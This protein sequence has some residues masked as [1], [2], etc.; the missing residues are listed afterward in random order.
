MVLTFPRA[1]I[2]MIWYCCN[3]DLLY[4]S[5]GRITLGDLLSYIKLSDSTSKAGGLAFGTIN[6]L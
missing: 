5:S 3:I 1:V 2:Q 6:F 4:A